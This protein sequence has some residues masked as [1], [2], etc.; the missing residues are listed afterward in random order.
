M[1]SAR[2][3]LTLSQFNHEPSVSSPRSPKIAWYRSRSFLAYACLAVPAALPV[4]VVVEDFV[5]LQVPHDV[6]E[7]SWCRD[8]FFPPDSPL[9]RHLGL[10]PVTASARTRPAESKL[11]WINRPH[12]TFFEGRPV[13]PDPITTG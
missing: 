7:V 11:R 13:A 3:Y 8:R 10:V 9:T 5:R 6:E 12:A 4:N 1:E 2:P